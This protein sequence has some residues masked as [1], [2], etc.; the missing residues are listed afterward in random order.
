MD[1]SCGDPFNADGLA[2]ASLNRTADPPNSQDRVQFEAE[3]ALI[4]A[5]T[6]RIRRVTPHLAEA[7]E[8]VAL[9]QAPMP[10]RADEDAQTPAVPRGSRAR[11]LILHKLL[12]EV[13]TGETTDDE[14]ALTT[15]AAELARQLAEAS[16]A[17]DFDAAE[18]ALSVLR[19]LAVPEI[20]AL[21][22]SLLPEYPV[23]HSGTGTARKW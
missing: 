12:E 7:N 19:G 11:G 1:K 10:I 22:A 6:H 15:R 2:P 16:G 18:A 21:R 17:E 9:E 14:A 13:L 3:A 4:A 8:V 5:R 20:A 23:A